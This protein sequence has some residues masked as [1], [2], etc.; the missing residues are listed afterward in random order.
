MNSI[1]FRCEHGGLPDLLGTGL[2]GGYDGAGAWTVVLPALRDS[3][4]QQLVETQEGLHHELR[5]SS[6]WGLV[7]AMAS[8]LAMRGTRPASALSEPGRQSV[9]TAMLI[10]RVLRRHED[11]PPIDNRLLGG[12]TELAVRAILGT[13]RV[14]EQGSVA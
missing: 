14:P 5:V 11:R 10:E 7:S 1:A 4:E 2:L 3:D 9:G 8:L 13:W 12:G 6:A